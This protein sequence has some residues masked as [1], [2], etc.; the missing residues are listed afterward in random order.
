M[1]AHD[2]RIIEDQKPQ[3]LM[4]LVRIYYHD[5]LDKLIDPLIRN[6]IDDHSF[7]IFKEVACQ[8]ITFKSKDRPKMDN[9]IQCIEEAL[10]VQVSLLFDYI[11][12]NLVSY[13]E[14]EK[15]CSIYATDLGLCDIRR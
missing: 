3:T 4:N 1:L 5:G 13:S 7:R 2:T 11:Q 15:V 6:Q 10:D 12:W 14:N 9:I 8:C